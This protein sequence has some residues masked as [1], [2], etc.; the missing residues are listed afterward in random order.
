M[1][2]AIFTVSTPRKFENHPMTGAESLLWGTR[3]G[4]WCRIMKLMLPRIRDCLLGFGVLELALLVAILVSV[5][6]FKGIMAA[7]Q[8]GDPA[9]QAARQERTQ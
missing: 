4:V 8:I 5:A 9:P 6:R 3:T 2:H 1:I 7:R